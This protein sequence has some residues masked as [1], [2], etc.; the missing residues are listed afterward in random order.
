MVEKIFPS[1][2]ERILRDL[3]TIVSSARFPCYLFQ[4]GEVIFRQIGL[5][6]QIGSP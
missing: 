6:Q 5:S 1:G 2:E 4:Q 3:L